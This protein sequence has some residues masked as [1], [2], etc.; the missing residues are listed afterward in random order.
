M[1]YK[2]LTSSCSILSNENYVLIKIALFICRTDNALTL[3]ISFR[4]MLK[5][6]LT[7]HYNFI[8]IKNAL[9][10]EGHFFI[11]TF[12][13]TV[14]IFKPLSK[15]HEAGNTISTR[16]PCPTWLFTSMVP[17]CSKINCFVIAMPKPVPS[18]AS[19]VFVPR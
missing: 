1:L 9:L 15:I 8:C 16:V 18:R 12:Q 10:E 19:V 3:Q 17:P 13:M 6:Y 5:I 14:R 7:Y 2:F 11:V 4:I